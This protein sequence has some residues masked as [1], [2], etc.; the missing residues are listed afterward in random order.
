V[1]VFVT[2]IVAERRGVYRSGFLL[3]GLGRETTAGREETFGERLVRVRL[4][5]EN[6]V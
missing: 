2:M 6:V 4:L 5:S 1:L 3:G